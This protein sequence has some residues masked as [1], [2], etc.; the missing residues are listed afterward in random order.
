[1]KYELRDYQKEAS[2]AAVNFFLDDSKKYNALL[3]CPTG[4]G[5]SLIIANIA[6][7]LNSDILVFCPSK[8]ILEQN[9]E[10]AKSYG[11]ECS[12]YSASVGQKEISR[13]TF[14]TIG[15]VR[16][17]SELFR[18]FKYVL[19]DEAHLVNPKKGMYND[20]LKQL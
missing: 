3:V 8:E 13:V 5:K 2:D 19:I 7:R 10:K 11:I 20:F 12:M 4:S 17:Y 9:Y 14:C 1:M 6:N 18:H 16:N 15:S